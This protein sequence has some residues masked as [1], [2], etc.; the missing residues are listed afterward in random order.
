[1]NHKRWFYGMSMLGNDVL[2]C[3][4]WNNTALSSCTLYTPGNDTWNTFPSLP[5]HLRQLAMLTLDS[6]F[7]GGQ[8]FV[9]GGRTNVGTSNVNTVYTFEDGAWRAR[10]HMPHA[11]FSHAAVQ[12]DNSTAMVCG[13]WNSSPAMQ[14]DCYL[15]NAKTDEWIATAKM[16]TARAGHG[17]AVYNSTAHVMCVIAH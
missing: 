3:G 15:Y 12:V 13:G 5:V 1:M 11:L 16:N 7:G 10:A 9:F 14:S 4:G 8:P 6:G 17:M 2:V